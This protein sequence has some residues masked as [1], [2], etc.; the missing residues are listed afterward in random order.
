M[1]A[2]FYTARMAKVELKLPHHR[3]E[4]L[5]E[6]G[7]LSK[8]GPLV[9]AVAPNP[10]AAL[11][12]D[13][14]V[15][16]VYGKTVQRSLES[17]GYQVT[18]HAFKAGEE[19]K[20]L[21]NAGL[22]YEVLIASKL[23]RKSPVLALGGGVAGDTVGFVAGTYQ[24]GVPFVQIPTTLL[25]MVDSSVGGK[26]GVNLPGGKNMVGVFHQ[27][28]LVILDT[29]V[30]A[31]L[32]ARELRC[33]LAECVKHGVIRDE[34]LFKWI[35]AN[36]DRIFQLDSAALVELVTRNVQIKANV[37]MADEKE[38]G[39]RAHLN[40]GHTFGHAIEATCGY[41]TYHHGEAISLG[42]VAATRLAAALKLCDATLATR[43]VDLLD[44]VG[45]PTSASDLAPTP[46]LLDK[47][48]VDKKVAG[49]KIRLVLPRKMGDIVI[50]SDVP[51]AAIADAWETIRA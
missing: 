26:T 19:N 18:A 41:G 49:G 17:A 16:S 25:A 48:R 27:P 1:P 8:M 32:P 21:A 38:M 51:D 3:Y 36:L 7:L 12:A 5:I 22:L 13:E 50:T 34:S 39:E 11:L 29:D 45:L 30:L 2:L 33:G 42:M 44:A 14:N 43:V 37:V 35:G 15:F 28:N 46:V 4:L 31:S 9:K 24:R 40:Y 23:E 6:P 10:R 47:M 20:T